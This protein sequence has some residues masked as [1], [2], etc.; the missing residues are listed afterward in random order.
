VRW[1]YGIWHR[2]DASLSS[3]L[4]ERLGFPQ[5]WNGVAEAL[6]RV[7]FLAA[8][9]TP[10]A[11]LLPL[12]SAALFGRLSELGVVLVLAYVLE[13]VWLVP[14]MAKEDDYRLRLGTVTGLG[15][16]GLVGVALAVLLEAHRLAG[17][18]N[19]LD[20]FGLAWVV[21]SLGFLAGLVIAQPLLVH[22]WEVTATSSSEDKDTDN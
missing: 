15:L 14:R 20:A 10:L 19:A 17:H 16:A 22:E 12:P 8:L 6:L 1:N 13:A 11:F 5:I 7:A 18:G 21:A 4:V 9:V 2:I 3:L